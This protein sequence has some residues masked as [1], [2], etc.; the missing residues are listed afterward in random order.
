MDQEKVGSFIKKL[1]Q[2]NNLTQ[3][4]FALKLGV[5]YQAVSKWETGK[6]VPDIATLKEISKMFNIDI[7]EI[8]S[9]QL[10]NKSDNK[11]KL[12]IISLILALVLSLV[13]TFLIF[14]MINHKKDDLEIN[15]IT[16]TCE[17]FN[18]TGNL[19]KNND[20]SYIRISNI[21]YCEDEDIVYKE[22]ECTLYE[23][24][25]DLTNKIAKCDKGYNEKLKEHLSMVKLS[26][27]D[28]SS[29]C[30]TKAKEL[31]IEINAI[32]SDDKTTTY[33]IPLEVGN[34]CDK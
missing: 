34:T 32:D 18:V 33:K 15:E 23:K 1:R 12:I 5:T 14:H 17:K 31:Y 21:E 13:V 25:G 22:I 20:K 2:D 6:N 11:K 27:N 3:A 7:D 26:A 19:I 24:N 30:S 28:Y 16:T 9:G 10:K 29:I 8:I 4:E